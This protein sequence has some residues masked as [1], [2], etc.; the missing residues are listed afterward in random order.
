MLIVE[1]GWVT[2]FGS[3]IIINTR[4]RNIH[5]EIP[6]II[7]KLLQYYIRRFHVLILNPFKYIQIEMFYTR[8][9]WLENLFI[10]FKN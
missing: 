5:N 7:N 9:P 2:Q 10:R 3:S 1:K 8:N 4:Y 6:N